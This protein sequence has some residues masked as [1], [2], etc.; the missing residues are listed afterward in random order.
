M[1]VGSGDPL[2]APHAA[3]WHPPSE[4]LPDV[5]P[6][7]AG[8]RASP[9]TLLIQHCPS[10]AP[11]GPGTTQSNVNAAHKGVEPQRAQHDAA[12]AVRAACRSPSG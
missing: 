8:C 5:M 7:C 1:G 12:E 6:R 4:Q 9:E 11:V 10:G 2:H 3:S